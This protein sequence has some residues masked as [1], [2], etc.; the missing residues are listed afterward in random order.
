M[1]RGWWRTAADIRRVIAGY[2]PTHIHVTNLSYFLL[3][4]P[5]LLL[6]RRPVVF[7]LPNPP[8][9]S[10]PGMKQRISDC[11]WRNCVAP[12]SS[13][14]VCNSRFTRDRLQRTGASCRGV[15]VIYNCLPERPPAK[16]SD[17]PEVDRG[18]FNI[19]FLGRVRP[20]KG[21]DH[22]V[23][24]CLRLIREGANI[25]AYIAGEKDWQNP[26][27]EELQRRVAAEGVQARIR[28]LGEIEDVFGFL[29]RC[30]LH[31][32]PSMTEGFGQVLLEAKSC[33]LPSVAYR[34]GAIPEVIEHLVDGYICDDRTA[35]GLADAIRYFLDR[36]EALR[37]ARAA[38]KSSLAKFSAE[39]AGRAWAE[40]YSEL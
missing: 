35:D 32:L 20:L 30:D 14:L 16:V 26:F 11:V 28:F 2:R 17:A 23:D 1:L 34:S 5:A 3:A 15:R 33:S 27:A 39:A 24:A 25:D 19:A 38:A 8:D 18:R 13:A 10:L 36:P 40:L 12:L 21:V 22:L 31:V 6:S 4:Y 29:R 7:R 9:E 37:A